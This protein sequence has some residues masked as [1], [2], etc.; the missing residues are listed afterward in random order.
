M[1]G[2]FVQMGGE[3]LG[4][5]SSNACVVFSIGMKGENV[6][7]HL[8]LGGVWSMV[9]ST[10]ILFCGEGARRWILGCTGCCHR[11]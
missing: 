9:G 3:V 1:G 4:A 10:R 8:L 2:E 6:V 5:K 11:P 7:V